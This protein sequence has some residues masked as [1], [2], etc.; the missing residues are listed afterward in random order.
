[1]SISPINSNQVNSSSQMYPMNTQN[2]QYQSCCNNLSLPQQSQSEMNMMQSVMQVFTQVIGGL[3]QMLNSLIEKLTGGQGAA[4]AGGGNATA[5]DAQPK[6]KGFSDYLMD[7]GKN[8]FG[9]AT[10]FLSGGVVDFV[11]GAAK[12]GF[13]LIKSIF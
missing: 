7:F 11:G 10:D 9:K 3:M 1:M 8:L 6:E 12:K 13:N 2:Q 4:N 5:T